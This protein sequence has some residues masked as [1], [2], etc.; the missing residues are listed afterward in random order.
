MYIKPNEAQ[1]E[2]NSMSSFKTWN[3]RIS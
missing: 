1:R 3:H 2:D